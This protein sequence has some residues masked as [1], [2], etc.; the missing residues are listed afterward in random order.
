MTAVGADLYSCLG[1]D[2]GLVRKLLTWQEEQ[3][4]LTHEVWFLMWEVS[5]RPRQGYH[6][7][8]C[9]ACL[10][11]IHFRPASLWISFYLWCQVLSSPHRSQSLLAGAPARNPA[12]PS[13][14][15]RFPSRGHTQASSSSNSG[16]VP[17]LSTPYLLL[18]HF[19][20]KTKTDSVTSRMCKQTAIGRPSK[21]KY[22]S[23]L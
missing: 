5:R 9:S 20:G 21:S 8:L 6:L 19:P 11:K 10:P 2:P 7:G 15:L 16:P 12:S 18:N 22:F 4:V 3:C 14:P 23:S 1:Q 13:S 17:V